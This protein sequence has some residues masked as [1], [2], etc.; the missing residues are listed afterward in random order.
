MNNMNVTGSTVFYDLQTVDM[1]LLRK[2]QVA[3]V[4]S[5]G[6]LVRST[7]CHDFAPRSWDWVESSSFG[8]YTSIRYSHSKDTILDANFD[9]LPSN[10]GFFLQN[11][12]WDLVSCTC[13]DFHRVFDTHLSSARMSM[14]FFCISSVSP[15]I[16]SQ[17]SHRWNTKVWVIRA[18]PQW[19][20]NSCSQ[21]N[22]HTGT[23]FLWNI[24]YQS[25]M[26]VRTVQRVKVWRSDISM[27]HMISVYGKPWEKPW[28]KWWFN[29]NLWDLPSGK[30]LHNELERSTMI[31][32]IP[33]T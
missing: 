31:L 2:P 25:G 22:P 11:L 24:K 17:M 4:N 14:C 15:L 32:S 3:D 8:E 18:L 6:F 29:G 10:V 1:Q 16:F 5:R 26:K 23:S 20:Q 7:M 28:K 12:I 21:L 33:S 19:Y 27:Y 9:S 30:R 13:M